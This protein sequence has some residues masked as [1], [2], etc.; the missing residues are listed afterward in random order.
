MYELRADLFFAK[1][2][3]PE[4]DMLMVNG[5]LWNR[6]LTSQHIGAWVLKIILNL[7][8]DIVTAKLNTIKDEDGLY[9]RIP[10]PVRAFCL[11]QC[12]SDTDVYPK[13]VRAES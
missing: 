3:Q 4:F 8:M 7:F 2:S 11:R 6:F 9:R 10:M 5:Y 1:T 13:L 12:N